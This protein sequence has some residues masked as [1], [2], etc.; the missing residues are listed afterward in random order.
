MK[1]IGNGEEDMGV[2]AARA[3]LPCEDWVRLKL[4]LSSSLEFSRGMGPMPAVLRWLRKQHSKNCLS[5]VI[6]MRK[7]M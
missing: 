4:L 6:G 2:M 1:L 7:T 5:V 3:V